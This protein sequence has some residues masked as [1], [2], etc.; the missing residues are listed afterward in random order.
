MNNLQSVPKS[1]KATMFGNGKR[2]GTGKSSNKYRVSPGTAKTI[3]I[4]R[5]FPGFSGQYLFK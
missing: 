1:K 5:P 2:N 3:V 4:S